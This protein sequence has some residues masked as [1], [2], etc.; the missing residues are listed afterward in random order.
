MI[1]LPHLAF[2]MAGLGILAGCAAFGTNVRGNFLCQAPGG[3]CAPT[4]R[5]DDQALALIGA[6]AQPAS[7]N[8]PVSGRASAHSLRALKVVLSARQDRFGRWR[9]STVVYIEPDPAVALADYD[10]SGAVPA[11]LSL[12]EL[13]AGAPEITALAAAQP[14]GAGA[15]AKALVDA[16]LAAARGANSKTAVPAPTPSTATGPGASSVVTAPSFAADAN[17]EG[18]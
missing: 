12:S 2:G 4:S 5:I 7:A 6:E 16:V 10:G 3:T 11:R 15:D 18:L 13:A 8:V 14:M 17:A 1:R 9:E